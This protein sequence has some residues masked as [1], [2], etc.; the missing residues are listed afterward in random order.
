MEVKT[1]GKK[2]VILLRRQRIVQGT[3]KLSH[4]GAVAERQ[5]P[6]KSQPSRKV[7]GEELLGH[8]PHPADKPVPEGLTTH[9]PPGN[10]GVGG[11]AE[12]Q[13]P[14]LLPPAI[15]REGGD[16][17]LAV[18]ESPLGGLWWTL[19]HKGQYRKL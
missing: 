7:T 9:H 15:L 10:P 6:P 1:K 16:S 19:K 14:I 3:E 8:L 18:G 13:P 2:E 5:V 12:H 17:V 4:T 11:G